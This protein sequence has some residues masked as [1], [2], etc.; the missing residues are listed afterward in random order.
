MDNLTQFE[1]ND[2]DAPL[3]DAVRRATFARATNL[4][5]SVRDGSAM[6]KGKCLDYT[7]KAAAQE[8]LLT[9]R[10]QHGFPKDVINLLEVV[11]DTAN[12]IEVTP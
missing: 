12:A 11:G 1:T 8:A 10:R 9:M 3:L 5:V 6:I 2:S 7:T 4:C